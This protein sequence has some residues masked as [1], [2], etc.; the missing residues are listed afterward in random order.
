MQKKRS[1]TKLQEVMKHLREN[2]I[3]YKDH[4]KKAEE[5]LQKDEVLL[6]ESNKF[7][8]KMRQQEKEIEQKLKIVQEL[9]AGLETELAKRQDILEKTEERISH[10]TKN[11]NKLK[12]ELQTE[13]NEL[14][15]ILNENVEKEKTIQEIQKE[16]FEKMTAEEKL[17][18]AQ[19]E[20]LKS[21]PDRFK[22]LL[23]RKKEISDILQMLHHEE[24][25]L[26]RAI[27][28]L[29]IHAKSL[30]HLSD[31]TDAQ[32]KLAELE[33]QLGDVSSKKS[34]F[35][36]KITSLLSLLDW[37]TKNEK[38]GKNTTEKEASS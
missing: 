27:Q 30:H 16:I 8:Q 22:T 4:F 6:E 3:E 20:E 33:K 11:Y 38:R 2:E 26:K 34:F 36:D 10:I 29:T 31:F 35:K 1:E 14:R 25:D 28:K 7:L 21:I 15:T 17:I 12:S 9:S 18:S 13:H 23:E 32:E 37:D 24:D 5:E 19:E